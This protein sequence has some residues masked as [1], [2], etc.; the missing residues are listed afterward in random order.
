MGKK[1]GERLED[2]LWGGAEELASEAIGALGIGNGAQVRQQQRLNESAAE[3]NYR[4]GEKAAQN[5]YNRQMQM[6][7]RSYADQ[8]YSAMVNQLRDAGLSVGLIY[9]NGGSGGQ[10]GAMTGAPMGDT[11]GAVAGQANKP[12]SAAER[13]SAIAQRETLAMSK[14]IAES[15]EYKNYAEG[16]AALANAGLQEEEATTER[17]SR[18]ALIAKLIEDGRAQW[19]KN[20]DQMV[21]HVSP[22]SLEFITEGHELYGLYAIDSDSARVEKL[23]KTIGEMTRN[24]EVLDG[25]IEL[26]KKQ[27]DETEARAYDL[28]ASV[29]LKSTQA[30]TTLRDTIVNELN[31]Q[32][33]AKNAE[34]NRIN[35]RVGIYHEGRISLLDDAEMQLMFKQAGLDAEF[36]LWRQQREDFKALQNAYENL[37]QELITIGGG[38]MYSK[39]K[40]KQ[41]PKKTST[42]RRDVYETYGEGKKRRRRKIGYDE[43]YGYE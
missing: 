8:S 16:K 35:A 15:Q 4:W 43:T 9:G 40:G 29:L 36:E 25:T 34:T 6:Y 1:F 23:V 22:E 10:G 33:N 39:L 2:F 20:L 19:I 13:A 14:D 11:G 42:S 26:L 5:A 28:W 41:P 3:T 37:A 27:A 17:E 7:E 18:D 32:T 31:A 30:Q 24:N 21:E 38:V 12:M